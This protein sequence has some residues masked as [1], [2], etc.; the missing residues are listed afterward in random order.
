M[1]VKFSIYSRFYSTFLNVFVK[2]SSELLLT[3][4]T[5]TVLHECHLVGI[6]ELMFIL[7]GLWLAEMKS[8]HCFLFI[9]AHTANSVDLTI[10]RLSLLRH[11]PLVI[12]SY[13]ESK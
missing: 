8:G 9:T 11:I 5:A 3:L 10:R 1:Y 6:D 4:M 12:S 13:R 7:L 2:F